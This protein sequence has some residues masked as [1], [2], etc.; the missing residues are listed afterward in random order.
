MNGID[1][2]WFSKWL[3]TYSTLSHY[4]KEC[5]IIFGKEIQLNW[6]EKSSFKHMHLKMF[7]AK[8]WPFFLSKCIIQNGHHWSC[9]LTWININPSIDSNH[10]PSKLCEEIIYPFQQMA[11]HLFR[12]KTL[13]PTK[14]E[15]FGETKFSEIGIQKLKHLNLKMFSSKWWPFFKI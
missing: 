12:A 13:P 3:V 11:C 2:C 6:N 1:H 14:T 5:W 7:S 8:W 9:L 10:M 15:L 4:P